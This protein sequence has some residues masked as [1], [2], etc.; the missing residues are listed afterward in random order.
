MT[1]IDS[2]PMALWKIQAIGSEESQV[3]PYVAWRAFTLVNSGIYFIPEPGADGKYFIQFLNFATGKVTTVA[4]IPRPP[5]LGFS[6]SPDEHSILYAQV[7]ES[8]SDLMLVEN[9]R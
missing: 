5:Y 7:D 9:F 4:T 6:V 8:K 1:G 3:L 2:A